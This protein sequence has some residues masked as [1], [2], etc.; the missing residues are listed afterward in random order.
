MQ[1]VAEIRDVPT[2]LYGEFVT[3][4]LTVDWWRP[5]RWVIILYHYHMSYCT[6]LCLVKLCD[7]VVSLVLCEVLYVCYLCIT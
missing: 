3:N 1:D 2:V 7:C 6:D 5:K 4:C